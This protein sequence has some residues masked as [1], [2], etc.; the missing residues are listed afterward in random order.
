MEGDEGEEVGKRRQQMEA[1]LRGRGVKIAAA[2]V[3]QRGVGGLGPWSSESFS[4]PEFCVPSIKGL[5]RDVLGD[6]HHRDAA[7]KSEAR[8]GG[9]DLDLERGRVD[10]SG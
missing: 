4:I 8:R 10:A 5:F 6:G 1:V 2:L 3:Q 7:L 9:K